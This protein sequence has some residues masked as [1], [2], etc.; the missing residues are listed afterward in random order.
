MIIH[1]YKRKMSCWVKAALVRIAYGKYLRC[2][3]MSICV[4]G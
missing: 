4:L 3:R 1:R 2:I